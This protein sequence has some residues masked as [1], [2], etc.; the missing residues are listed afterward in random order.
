M[1]LMEVGDFVVV[2]VQEDLVLN[3]NDKRLMRKL[4]NH[5]PEENDMNIQI[6]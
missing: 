3:L 2:N 4:V 1:D 5:Y 6:L